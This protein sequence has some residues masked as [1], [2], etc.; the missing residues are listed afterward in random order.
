MW[1][2]S[3]LTEYECCEHSVYRERFTSSSIFKRMQALASAEPYMTE[4]E[5]IVESRDDDK[6]VL[7]ETHFYAESGGQ[8]PDRGTLAGEKIDDVQKHDGEIVHTLVETP[9]I[10]VGD[11]VAG[12]IDP[13]FRMYCMR[14]HTASHVLYGAG[15]QLFDDLAYSGF[16]IDEHKVRV[17]LATPTSIDDATLVTL[18]RLVNRTVL[19]SRN[20][21]W[22]TVPRETALA[23]N[24]VA[25]NI[26]TEEGIRDETVRLVDIDGWDIAACGGTHVRNTREIGP[27][28]ILDRSNPGKGVTRVEFA[29]GPAAI[30][31]RSAEKTAALDAAAALETRVTDL[32]DAV[33]R[34]QNE[35]DALATERTELQERLIDS[36]LDE[37]RGS[38]VERDGHPWLIGTIDY[39]DTNKLA[40]QANDLAGSDADVVA[41]VSGDG[42]S[43]AVAADGEI[44]ASEIVNEL[45]TEFGGGGGGSESVAQ[46]GGFDADPDDLVAFLRT[47]SVETTN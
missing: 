28:A 36:R 10:E 39:L 27:V 33:V 31:H 12:R 21:T 5:A 26:K 47:G 11:T 4:F 24:D 13:A 23:C 37:L 15:R 17:D 46:A 25:F 35:R 3:G 1:R 30:Q 8:P 6:L 18:E 20:V 34:L 7:D 22:E 14:A 29:V 41:L 16:N 19:D 2:L 44:D 38:V 45:T 40:E 32:S 42:E 43:T 9:T